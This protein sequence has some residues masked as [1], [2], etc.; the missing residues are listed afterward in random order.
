MAVGAIVGYLAFT[1]TLSWAIF[2][3]RKQVHSPEPLWPAICCHEN[4][5]TLANVLLPLGYVTEI[6]VRFGGHYFTGR[7][8]NRQG[9]SRR[10]RA[11]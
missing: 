5:C 4:R 2:F 3:T 10:R 7:Q 6:V 1:L 9:S 11:H 8:S